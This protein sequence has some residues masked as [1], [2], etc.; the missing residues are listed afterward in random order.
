LTDQVQVMSMTSVDIDQLA[1][2]SRFMAFNARIEIQR[3]GPSGETFKVLSD[4]INKAFVQSK[5]VTA[6][7]PSAPAVA[8]FPPFDPEA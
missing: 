7:P 4:E 1:N 8:L 3:A 6:T 5:G 2:K